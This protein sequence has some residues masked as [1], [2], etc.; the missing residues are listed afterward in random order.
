MTPVYCLIVDD[1][2]LARTL[3]ANYT[4]RIPWLELVGSVS[5]P[6]EA[7]EV[8]REKQVDLMFLDIQMPEI[9]G[10]AF[11]RSLSKK[12]G[13]IFTTAYP[14]YALEGFNLDACDYL[15]KPFGFDRFLQAV[16]KALAIIGGGEK[17]HPVSASEE[18]KDFIMIRSEHKIHRIRY[19]DILYIQSMREYAAF[20]TTHGRILSLTSLKSLE[21][22]LPARQFLRIHKSYIIGIN[23]VD[24]L[25]GNMVH[26]GQAALPV[27]ASYRDQLLAFFS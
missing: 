7:S 14:E 1:E 15:L 21:E 27:G 17:A 6:V 20:Y 8:L 16:N 24:T 11:L 26:I 12:P 9:N 23:H 10:L 13:V 2:E 19:S 18:A 3:L 5:N 22:S 4:A 25:E